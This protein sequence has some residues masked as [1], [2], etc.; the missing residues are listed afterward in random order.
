MFVLM[1]ICFMTEGDFL[2]LLLTERFAVGVVMLGSCIHYRF[3]RLRLLQSPPDFHQSRSNAAIA[4]AITTVSPFL[5]YASI[6]D[7]LMVVSSST[8]KSTF[9]VSRLV[10]MVIPFSMAQRRICAPSS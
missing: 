6:V 7:T 4:S 9:T 8:S 3:S 10:S 2:F 1:V 5:C